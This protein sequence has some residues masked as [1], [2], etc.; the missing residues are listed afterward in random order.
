M[1][2]PD[3]T[4]VEQRRLRQLKVLTL[5][6]NAAMIHYMS[7]QSTVGIAFGRHTLFVTFRNRKECQ[8]F[9]NVLLHANTVHRYTQHPIFLTRHKTAKCQKK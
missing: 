9:T 4:V 1:L 8:Q 7:S 2:F 6:S 3:D 5:Q